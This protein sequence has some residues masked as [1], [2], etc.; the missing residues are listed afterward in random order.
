M[1]STSPMASTPVP[2]SIK[3]GL[4]TLEPLPGVEL[5]FGLVSPS[6]S[7]VDLVVEMLQRHL[8]SVGYQTEEIHISDLIDSV[9]GGT[10]NSLFFDE[11]VDRLMTKGT[12]LRQDNAPDVCARLAIAAV[13]QIRQERNKEK[14]PGTQR[15]ESQALGKMAFVF[16][17]LKTTEEVET[18]RIIYGQAF[19]LISIYSSEEDRRENLARRIGNSRNDTDYQRYE[20]TAQELIYRDNEEQ[21]KY[22][23]NVKDTFPLADLFVA[24]DLN[25]PS[26]L[27]RSIERFVRLLF[28]DPFV[29]PS[30][31]EYGMFMAKAVAMRSADLGRQVGATILSSQGDLMAAGCNEVPKFGGGQYWEGDNPDNR[32]FRIG[33]DSSVEQRNGAIAE[34][35]SR[36]SDANWL[37]EEA[38]NKKPE[39]LAV[40][41]IDGDVRE[42]F[43]NSQIL[44]ILEYGR[45]VH[46]EMAAITD[47]AKRGV[48][49]A[50][51]TIFSTTF[52]CHLC[53]RH[54]VAAGMK[55]VVYIEPYT[56]SKAHDLYR[57]SIVVNPP[58][59]TAGKV[60]FQP[61]VGIS[62][63]RF[64]YFF[65]P[66][67]ERKNRRGKALVWDKQQIKKS[68]LKRYVASYIYMEEDAVKDLGE[69]VSRKEEPNGT[70]KN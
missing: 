15:P 56:K 49:I 52:P 33:T 46:A 34:L 19:N 58:S 60:M 28:G 25:E 29:T 3:G 4:P 67:A 31:D 64:L 26:S 42:K 65:Q 53:A 47:A 12:E 20:S 66:N 61:F 7:R 39:V 32:D 5:F 27:D 22:G 45:S 13:R 14:M 63:N 68:R 6:G 69:I 48:A 51:A 21:K 41:M 35:I 9:S 36:F 30:R 10:A 62:P 18:L 43:S 23:Q 11:R 44:G 40:E 54:I 57:D 38:K 1:T 16:R 8:R 37:S 70:Q 24:I 2:A 59:E 50:G 17:S 55:R